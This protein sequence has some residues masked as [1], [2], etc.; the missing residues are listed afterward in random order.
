RGSDQTG[1]ENETFRR[2]AEDCRVH[3]AY[4]KLRTLRLGW[5]RIRVRNGTEKPAL[6]VSAG[7]LTARI[8]SKRP[9]K[10]GPLPAVRMGRRQLAFASS[11][12]SAMQ[13]GTFWAL[14]ADTFPAWSFMV[15]V[16]VG[17]GVGVGGG[18]GALSSTVRP[19][20]CIF[21]APNVFV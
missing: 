2:L 5:R 14:V 4:S 8:T 19:L 13:C 1:R 12:P 21:S 15:H 6:R 10:P 3:G 20:S 16:G 7:I 18:V 17:V 9:G 11:L